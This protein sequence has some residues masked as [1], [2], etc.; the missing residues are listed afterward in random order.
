MKF[1]KVSNGQYVSTNM[2]YGIQ[3]TFDGE[4][5][6]FKNDGRVDNK[7]YYC[8]TCKYLK[9]A[10][11]YVTTEMLVEKISSASIYD[12]ENFLGYQISADVLEDLEE[13]IRKILNVITETELLYWERRFL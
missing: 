4:W 3:K 12:I 6:V 5:S 1:K 2:E 7:L 8:V 13:R 10:K 9:N 11:R